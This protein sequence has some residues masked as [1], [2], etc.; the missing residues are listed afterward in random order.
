[1][2]LNQELLNKIRENIASDAGFINWKSFIERITFERVGIN[3]QISIHDEVCRQYSEQI[4]KCEECDGAGER[5][6]NVDGMDCPITCIF[7]EGKGY[8]E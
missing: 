8:Q 2:K 5:E 4:I 7:C 3:K 6:I 1:M